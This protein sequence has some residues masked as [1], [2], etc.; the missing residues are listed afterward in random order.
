ML[1]M[2]ASG[3]VAKRKAQLLKEKRIR[4]LEEAYARRLQTIYRA[5]IA[6]RK[7][8]SHIHRRVQY[9]HPSIHTVYIQ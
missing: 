8:C 1:F 5:H 7:V 6:K 2:L 3:K 4:L 9:I